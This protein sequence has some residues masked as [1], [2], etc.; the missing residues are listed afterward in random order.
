M[1]A[2]D[3]FFVCSSC[4]QQEWAAGTLFEVLRNRSRGEPTPC[5]C[6]NARYLKMMFP[7]ELGAGK[8]ECKVLGAFLPV[9]NPLA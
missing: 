8:Y 5:A 7:F 6:G 4:N 2:T 1:M 3:R 9:G